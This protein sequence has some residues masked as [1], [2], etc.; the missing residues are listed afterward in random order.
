[1][2]TYYSKNKEYCKKKASEYYQQNRLLMNEKQKIYY[3]ENKQYFK[4]K[5]VE[6]Y[7]KNRL[8][9]NEK[10]KTYYQLNKEHCKMKSLEYYHKNKLIRNEKHKYYFR[11][12]YY[13][14]HRT[15]HA[16][17][18]PLLRPQTIIS[19]ERNFKVSL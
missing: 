18:L 13:P 10:H 14:A 15:R 1:M 17:E 16:K 9:L 3:L 2:E 6:Y 5:L 4:M 12:I 19:V 7:N 8:T 11:N